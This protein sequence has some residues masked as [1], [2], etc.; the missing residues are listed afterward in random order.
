MLAVCT[1]ILLLGKAKTGLIKS[2]TGV[3]GWDLVEQAFKVTL[4][5][6]DLETFV[7]GAPVNICWPLAVNGR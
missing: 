4:A 1:T 5:V 7:G 6:A 2:G 3:G